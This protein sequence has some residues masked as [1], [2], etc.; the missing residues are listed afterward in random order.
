MTTHVRLVSVDDVPSDEDAH[1]RP[2]LF[3]VG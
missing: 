2:L 1:R 3:A